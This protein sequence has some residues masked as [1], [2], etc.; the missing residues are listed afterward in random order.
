MNRDKELM[1]YNRLNS[2][3]KKK[4]VFHFGSGMGFYSEL[5]N[6]IL[7]MLYCLKNG[8][9][10][11]M[12]SKDASFFK[13][14]GWIDKFRPFCKESGLYFHHLFNRR[15]IYWH[16]EN[17]ALEKLKENVFLTGIWIYKIA[18][19]NYL[20][21]DFFFECRTTWFEK[22][23]FNIPQ[24]NINCGTRE[25]AGKM[26]DIIYQFN[27]QYKDEIL[28]KIVELDLP[29]KYIGIHLRGG[30]K[31]VERNLY[32]YRTYMDKAENVTSVRTAFILTDDYSVYE[33]LV[34]DYPSWTFYTLT[35]KD[36]RGYD[37]TKFMTASQER[38]D[39]EL[40][41]VFASLEIM[42]KA[43]AFIG[44]YSSNP[45]MFL[46]MCMPIDKVYCLDNDH[47]IIL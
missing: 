20:T 11:R 25:A 29:D 46:G 13:G 45:G 27:P 12:Y 41:K 31:I 35:L 28:N 15:S 5:N 8:I 26:I 23:F 17:N 38:K 44:T 16:R 10:F 47:W 19:G 22:E 32:S 7:C 43:D 39:E 1:V 2:S 42:R 33:K 21:N 3:F 18:T 9:Q 30:D 37:N 40:L 36:E 24:L 14:K 34:L 6:M 4:L